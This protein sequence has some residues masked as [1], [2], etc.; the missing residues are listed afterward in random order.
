MDDSQISKVLDSTDAALAAEREN[1]R[2]I[3][4]AYHR[5]VFGAVIKD[6]LVHSDIH[7]GNALLGQ[8]GRNNSAS[9]ASSDTPGFILFDVGQ[10]ERIS[11]DETRAILWLLSAILTDLKNDR[12]A[13]TLR[14]IAINHLSSVCILDDGRNDGAVMASGALPNA[15]DDA[16]TEAVAAFDDGT[17]P[18][19][20]TAYM[21]FL[22]AAESRGVEMPKASFAIAKMIDGIL[23]Q[24]K[25]YDLPPVV[26]ETIEKFLLAN[27]SWV[28]MARI[29]IAYMS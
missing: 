18:D 25:E 11:F 22:R 14:Q 15:I 5:A 28:E 3:L 20:K 21:L 7:L 2:Q 16:F 1:T 23:V 13:G 9:S 17:R 19:H 29:C 8:V 10:F 6:C 26:D 12:L 4:T 24:Q 27:M